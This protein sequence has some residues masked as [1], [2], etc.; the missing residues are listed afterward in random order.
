MRG[1]ITIGATA[2]ILSLSLLTA[3]SAQASPYSLDTMSSNMM[4]ASDASTL[5][6]AGNHIRD[7]RYL[8]GTKES[9]DDFWLCDLAGGKEVEVDG[10]SEAYV[11]TY[12]SEKS[13]VERVAEQELYAFASAAD[14]RKAMKAIRRAAKQCAG[15]FRVQEE[16]VTF[17]QKV[18]NGT[19]KASDGS[20]FTWIKHE[21]TAS[22]ANANLTDNDYN[23]FRRVGQFVQVLSIET[24]GSKAPPISSTQVKSLNN[25][26]GTLGSAW[27]W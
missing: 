18:S 3:G 20:G 22:A 7:F 27:A 12:A 17:S 11:V 2:S 25:L 5:G 8:E 26:T 16:G 24:A 21:A 23:T 10:S 14:A 4:T 19:G 1:F 13:G 9:P 6:V 15:T